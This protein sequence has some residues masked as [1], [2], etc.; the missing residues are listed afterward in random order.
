MM[1][2]QDGH[3]AP[4]RVDQLCDPVVFRFDRAET[5]PAPC[6]K[7]VA[8]QPNFRQYHH[9]DT[10]VRYLG[11]TDD[12]WRN[13]YLRVEYGQENLALVRSDRLPDRL[14][15]HTVLEAL[16]AEHLITRNSGVLLHCAYI[17]WQKQAI[18]FTAPSGTGKST[19]A[20]LWQQFRGAEIINGDRAAIRHLNGKLYAEGV[21]FSGSSP[22]C[23]NVTLPLRAVVCLS[24]APVTSIRKMRGYEAF[25]RIWEGI[26]VQTWDKADVEAASALVKTVAETIPVYSLPCTPDETA[27][28]AL[29][30]ALEG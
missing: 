27:V 16:A 28:L 15:T 2:R 9:G 5:L 4:F 26:G 20:A 25:S 19:Q 7:C 1:Y 23:K 11:Q 30:Q 24:Q 17:G 21:P 18:L 6:G 12:D 10:Q 13:A 3:L 14:G 29:E 22:Y 8:V